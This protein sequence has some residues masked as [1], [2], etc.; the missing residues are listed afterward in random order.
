MQ[1]QTEFDA[2]IQR[3]LSLLDPQ[4]RSDPKLI[5]ERLHPEFVEFG[6]SGRVWDIE[7]I[8]I[9]LSTEA[10][11]IEMRAFDFVTTLISPAAILLTYRCESGEKKSLRSSI[12]SR[13]DE[14][15]WIL[16]FHQGTI[17]DGNLPQ[18]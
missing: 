15:S 7:S 14:G 1:D 4:V 10:D 8:L 17:I 16:L 3:E 5:R 9:A 11:P 18:G 2:V 13:T 12:W 6:A